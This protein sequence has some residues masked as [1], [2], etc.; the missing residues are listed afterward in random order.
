M[1]LPSE[2]PLFP[3][4]IV[5]FPG[6]VLPLHIFEPR[7]RR[8]LAVCLDQQIPFGL[9][10][11]GEPRPRQV[12]TAAHIER[13]ERLSDGRSNILTVGRERFR[14]TGFRHDEPYLVG[15]VE[16][17][18]CVSRPGSQQR[19]YVKRI[20]GYFGAYVELLRDTV[21]TQVSIE[22][23]PDQGDALGYL[24]AI[25]LQVG[26]EQKQRLLEAPTTLDLLR[27]GCRLLET[28][29]QILRYMQ[30]TRPLA[31]AAGPVTPN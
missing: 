2:L 11:D 23:T 10:L 7:Y 31:D 26:L 19:R 12:G 28:E 6:M 15:R 14:V 9:I 24:V 1:S 8:M 13:V 5:L 17:W 20:Q 25:A 21:G 3:L 30:R 29:T 4:N 16:E 27:E 18:P 22:Q